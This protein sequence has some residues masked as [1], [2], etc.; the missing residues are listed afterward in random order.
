VQEIISSGRD[1]GTPGSAPDGAVMQALPVSGLVLTLVDADAD[2]WALQ[3][4]GSASMLAYVAGSGVRLL[5]AG[6][7][8]PG[9]RGGAGLALGRPPAHP[10]HLAVRFTCRRL[11]WRVEQTVEVTPVTKHIWVAEAAGDF[12]LAVLE[13]DGEALTV[14]DLDVLRPAHAPRSPG[15]ARRSQRTDRSG[16]AEEHPAATSTDATPLQ[17]A[18]N[19]ERSVGVRKR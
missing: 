17:V 5:D 4:A 1:R 9:D 19:G 7:L 3:R 18:A 13:V 16:R 10:A 6:F 2:V 14:V 15:R 11:R 8:L 12:D